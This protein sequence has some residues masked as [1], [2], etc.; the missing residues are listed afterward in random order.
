VLALVCDGATNRQIARA[1]TISER[2]AGV[3]VSN[4]LA[5]LHA[6][7]RAEAIAIAHRTGAVAPST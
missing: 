2:T 3:H 4:I 7:N 5:K 6:R 1:L